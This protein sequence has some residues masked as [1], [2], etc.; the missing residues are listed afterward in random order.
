ME[1]SIQEQAKSFYLFTCFIFSVEFFIFIYINLA[2]FLFVLLLGILSLS[3]YCKWD[4][5]FRYIFTQ[6]HKNFFDFVLLITNVFLV[7]LWM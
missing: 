6:V 4:I 3:L 5:S 1:F 7:V 2:Y